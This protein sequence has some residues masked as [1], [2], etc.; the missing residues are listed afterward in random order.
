M[1]HEETVVRSA[2]A[3]LSFATEQVAVAR[4]AMEATGLA[5]PKQLAG[6]TSDQRIA[7]AQLNITLG[8]FVVG[9]VT[10]IL[11]KKATGL[12]APAIGEKLYITEGY[13]SYIDNRQE[14]HW[15]EPI[16]KWVPADPVP[17]ELA[18]MDLG[19]FLDSQW[20]QTQAWATYAS[21]SVTVTFQ[22]K[23]AGP[24]KALFLFGHDDK[25]NETVEPED[26]TVDAIVLARVMQKHLFADALISSRLR[27][28][29][30]VKNWV[31]AKQQPPNCA[32]DQGVCCDPSSLHCGPSATRVEKAQQGGVQ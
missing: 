11:S 29:P 3:K 18:S 9:N 12:I 32:E 4:L 17:T 21:Y 15:F 20:H 1:T 31:A 14:Y 5:T 6:L 25:G 26:G 22:G 13:H 23:S 8:D 27:D 24:Y 28:V 2:Y 30:L 19:A 7:D 10:D 16:P